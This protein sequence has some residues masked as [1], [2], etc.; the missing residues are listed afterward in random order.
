M[1]V[2]EEKFI[3]N[4]NEMNESF[5]PSVRHYHATLNIAMVDV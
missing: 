3:S 1:K 2:M 5:N 4:A